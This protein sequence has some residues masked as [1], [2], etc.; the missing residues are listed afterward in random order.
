MPKTLRKVGKLL[1]GWPF[2]YVTGYCVIME[3]LDGMN[4]DHPTY[5]QDLVDNVTQIKNHIYGNYH[6]D[7]LV[8]SALLA[9]FMKDTPEI[10]EKE[11]VR[12][13]PYRL[14]LAC[15]EQHGID[16]QD[17]N[18]ISIEL[19]QKWRNLNTHGLTIKQVKASTEGEN[20]DQLRLENTTLLRYV[21]ELHSLL[22]SVSAR[23]TGV[24]A[25]LRVV[26]QTSPVK[27]VVRP[28]QNR[29]P[30][31]CQVPYAHLTPTLHPPL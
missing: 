4:P 14:T 24:E 8:V 11:G 6:L 26:A 30:P 19:G 10:L 13:L 27:Q 2:D 5:N 16:P 18:R 31:Q 15:C 29:L 23:L 9:T 3:D 25:G 7:A 17:Y 22:L 20:A 12:H 1:A 28:V 21:K